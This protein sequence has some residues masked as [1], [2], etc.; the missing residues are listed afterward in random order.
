MRSQR[1]VEGRR[2]L[3][4]DR[5]PDGRAVDL[6]ADADRVEAGHL[7]PDP[8][9]G[10][11]VAAR[12]LFEGSQEVDQLRVAVGVVAEVALEALVK[13][14]LAYPSSKLLEHRGALLIRDGVEVQVD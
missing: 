13:T 7:Q 6:Q 11:E 10:L 12:S 3:L 9:P 2:L 5:P 8:R 14:L 4:D 1:G